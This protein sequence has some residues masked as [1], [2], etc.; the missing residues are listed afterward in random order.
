MGLAQAMVS[1]ARDTNIARNIMVSF[2]LI[3]M[4]GKRFHPPST[5]CIALDQ[6]IVTAIRAVAS[7]NRKVDI[8]QGKLQQGLHDR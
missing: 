7:V 1:A 5:V 3:L 6:S 8:D 4:F 2:R